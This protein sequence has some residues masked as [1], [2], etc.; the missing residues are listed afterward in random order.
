MGEA[1]R[2]IV[3]GVDGSKGALRA[4]AFAAEEARLRG[5]ALEVIHAWHEPDTFYPY[6]T[7]TADRL[8]ESAQVGA[9]EAAQHTLDRA[10][11][12]V[13]GL[14][15]ITVH[16]RVVGDPPARALVDASR[17]ADLLV[18][19]SRGRGGFAGLLLGSVSQQCVQHAACP[20]VVTPASR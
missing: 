13:G 15:G 10:L 17:D 5:A 3:V 2:K 14:E 16:T 9:H 20:V 4:L 19:G 7:V 11:H 6:S 8:R 1:V 18:V 12:E